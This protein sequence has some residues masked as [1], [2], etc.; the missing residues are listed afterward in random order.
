M[1]S[2]I[3]HFNTFCE[4]SIETLNPI[5][6]AV[7]V[8]LF[9]YN[10]KT[11]WAEWFSMTTAR[12]TFECGINEKTLSAARN[13]LRQKGFIDFIPGKK[14]Q[15]TKYHLIPFALVNKNWTQN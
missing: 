10:N 5:C 13:T 9:A 12:L 7:Y 15:P 1:I 14:N 3:D 8:R 2:Y 11:G 6:M 4:K